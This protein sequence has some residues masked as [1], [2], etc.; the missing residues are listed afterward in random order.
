MV[1]TSAMDGEIPTI[2]TIGTG[3]GATVMASAG[4]AAAVGGN[5]SPSRFMCS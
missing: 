1:Q 5:S 4:T 2:V 3:V